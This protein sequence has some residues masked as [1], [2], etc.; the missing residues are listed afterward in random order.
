MTV[1]GR[2]VRLGMHMLVVLRSHNF[3][4]VEQAADFLGV[5]TVEK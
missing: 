1:Y 5:M 2:E 3:E 4:S